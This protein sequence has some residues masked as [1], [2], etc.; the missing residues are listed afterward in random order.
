MRR[1]EFV[2]P[3]F[4]CD[5]RDSEQKLYEDWL[6]RFDSQQDLEAYLTEKTYKL[7][8]VD[9]YDFQTWKDKAKTAT[10]VANAAKNKAGF[11]YDNALWTELKQYLFVISKGKCGY[12]E[13][14]VTGVYAGDVEH[15][16]PKKKVTDDPNHPGYYWLAYDER[17]YVPVCQK[18]NGA[19]AKANHFPLDPNSK[20]ASAPG[21]DLSLEQPLLVN[22][23]GSEDPTTH[24]AFVGPEGGKEFG[25]IIGVTEA[26]KKSS[27][28]YHLNRSELIEDRRDAYTTMTANKSLLEAGWQTVS[29]QL[30]TQYKLGIKEFTLVI[31]AVLSNWLQEIRIK[32]Q[33]SAVDT[34]KAYEEEIRQVKLKQQAL[35][36]FID[37]DLAMLQAGG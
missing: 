23:L 20:R 21:A 28:I 24:F 8:S 4:I 26:G 9:T 18:C 7:E 5:V 6:F 19:R 3:N 13:Q 29:Q 37:N 35:E 16:R 27:E 11:E 1:L 17:N 15:Y 36:E 34:I 12:C 25:K 31:R 22:P 33:Q 2:E 32:Q 10:D 14:K 30:M